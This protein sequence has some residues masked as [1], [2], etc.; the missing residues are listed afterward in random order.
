[1]G[2]M[3]SDSPVENSGRSELGVGG[4]VIRF[5]QPPHNP[6]SP[7]VWW[8]NQGAGADVTHNRRWHFTAALK[9]AVPQ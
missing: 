6:V 7:R 5:V 3:A 8:G 2:K 4:S 9:P 1:M